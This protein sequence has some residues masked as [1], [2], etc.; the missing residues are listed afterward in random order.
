MVLSLECVEHEQLWYY[1]VSFVYQ[2]NDVG[3]T[4][5]GNITPTATIRILAIFLFPLKPRT[6]MHYT[7]YLLHHNFLSVV[8]F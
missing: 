5:S 8:V 4:E 2:Y 6:E 1:L 7:G 3:L